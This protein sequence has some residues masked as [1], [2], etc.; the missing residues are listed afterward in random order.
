MDP[1]PALVPRMLRAIFRMGLAEYDRC[2]HKRWYPILIFQ[3]MPKGLIKSLTCGNADTRARCVRESED[4]GA[5]LERNPDTTNYKCYQR[6]YPGENKC[7]PVDSTVELSE[8][9]LCM[10][11]VPQERV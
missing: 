11:I 2:D 3:Y 10:H 8:F 1:S 9:S 4:G 5:Q 6:H 7:R